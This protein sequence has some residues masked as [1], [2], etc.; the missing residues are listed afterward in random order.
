LLQQF[1]CSSKFLIAFLAYP[2]RQY[3]IS[4]S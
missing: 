3:M 4:I 1:D 2:Q